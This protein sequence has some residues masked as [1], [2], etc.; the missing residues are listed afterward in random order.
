ME[1]LVAGASAVQVGTA[2]F[3]D[4]TVAGRM[5]CEIPA[6]L[7][8]LGIRSVRDVVGTLASNRTWSDSGRS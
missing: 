1:F 8:E 6:Y 3:D 4:P 2:N 5:V 7:T